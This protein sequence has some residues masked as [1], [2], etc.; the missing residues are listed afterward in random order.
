MQAMKKIRMGSNSFC[1]GGPVGLYDVRIIKVNKNYLRTFPKFV[2][3]S[4]LLISNNY[5]IRITKA[6]LRGKRP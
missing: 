1:I 3:S 6:G 2:T 4:P 5:E